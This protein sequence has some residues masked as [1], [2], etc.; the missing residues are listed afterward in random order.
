MNALAVRLR[1]NEILKVR[2]SLAH[3]FAMPGYV[4]P[5]APSGKTR[6][7]LEALVWTRTFFNHIVTT[8]DIGLNHI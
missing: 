5:Q 6:L 1:L 8:M 3:G 2:H 4:W 7:A